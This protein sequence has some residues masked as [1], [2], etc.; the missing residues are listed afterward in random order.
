MSFHSVAYLVCLLRNS[1]FH[2]NIILWTSLFLFPKE[3]AH[4]PLRFFLILLKTSP[5]PSLDPHLVVRGPRRPS[6][7]WALQLPSLCRI[8]RVP[9]PCLHPSPRYCLGCLPH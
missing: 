8:Q 4:C 6:M 7:F 1:S 3:N 2:F 5:S 9:Q